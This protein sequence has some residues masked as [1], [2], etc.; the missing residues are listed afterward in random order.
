MVLDSDLAISLFVILI[1]LPRSSCGLG[2]PALSWEIPED[3]G[4][5]HEQ[6]GTWGGDRPQLA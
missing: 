5:D 2:L 4:E 3:F 6:G 1:E